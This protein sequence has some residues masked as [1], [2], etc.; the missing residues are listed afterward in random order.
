MKVLDFVKLIVLS[1]V[2]SHTHLFADTYK[3][4]VK[5]DKQTVKFCV[6]NLTYKCTDSF[7][8]KKSAV[9]MKAAIGRSAVA[10]KALRS[11]RE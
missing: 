10:W 1:V 6:H 7:S 11:A 8:V 5:K 9:R 2:I 3:L 4:E